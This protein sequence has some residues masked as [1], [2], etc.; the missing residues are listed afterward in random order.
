MSNGCS[1]PF[2]KRLLKRW[3]CGPL[4]DAQKVNE[5]LDA[6]TDLVL[7]EMIRDKL[8]AKLKKLPDLERMLSRIYTYSQKS[9]VKAI[10]IDISV[11]T[12][13]DEFHSLLSELKRLSE[14]LNDVFNEDAIKTLRSKRLRALVQYKN[15]V[16]KTNKKKKVIEDNDEEKLFPD[17]RP[18]I[19][20]FEDMIQWKNVGNKKVPE[21]TPGQ[22]E[23]FD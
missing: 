5:R 18:I 3:V 15:V 22:D 17:F 19:E 8:Q 16:K 12:R 14:I 2:G 7:Q 20:E 4:K 11:I 13:L 10:Y 21:P 1:T 23:G 6:V 9:S